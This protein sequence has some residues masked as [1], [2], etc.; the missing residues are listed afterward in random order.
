[1][2]APYRNDLKLSIV[3]VLDT[4]S[5]LIDLGFKRLGLGLVRVTYD[6]ERDGADLHLQRAHITMGWG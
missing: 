5:K 1:M 6:V 2:K 3:V 4:T